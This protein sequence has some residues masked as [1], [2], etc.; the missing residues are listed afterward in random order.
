MIGA[1]ID[2]AAAERVSAMIAEQ[3]AAARLAIGPALTTLLPRYRS[4]WDAT[5]SSAERRRISAEIW[6]VNGDYRDSMTDSL[7][8]AALVTHIEETILPLLGAYTLTLIDC[9]RFH[10]RFVTFAW[11]FLDRAG[12]F[13]PIA[14]A[15]GVDFVTVSADAKLARIVGFFDDNG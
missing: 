14:G 7:S 11:A 3:D 12:S 2:A 4:L 13:A 1:P 5:T 15:A 6:E 10:G 8:P 9:P